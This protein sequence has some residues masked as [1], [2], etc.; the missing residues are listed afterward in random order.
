MP[1]SGFPTALAAPTARVGAVAIAP[2]LAKT[3]FV[4]V[5]TCIIG[6]MLYKL[7]KDEL[8]WD[9]FAKNKIS[10]GYSLTRPSPNALPVISVGTVKKRTCHSQDKQ[11]AGFEGE[12]GGRQH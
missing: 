12:Q 6:Y 2:L 1:M 3:A 10:N 9:E 7:V 8:R 5:P 4:L 11:T